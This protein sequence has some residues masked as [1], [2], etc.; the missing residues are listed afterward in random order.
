[1]FV[2]S[3]SFETL[4]LILPSHSQEKNRTSSNNCKTGTY[5]LHGNILVNSE[6]PSPSFPQAKCNRIEKG[7]RK[8]SSFF[9]SGQYLGNKEIIRRL[10]TSVKPIRPSHPETCHTPSPP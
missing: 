5:P 2:E 4:P 8:L 3:F 6:L 9:F 7:T 1:M 10:S